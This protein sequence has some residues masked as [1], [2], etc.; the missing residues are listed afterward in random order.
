[1]LKLSKLADYAVVVLARLGDGEVVQ[2][3]PH[4]AGKTGLPRAYGCQGPQGISERWTRGQPA[5]RAGR[6][7]PGAS[8]RRCVTVA[9]VVSAIDGPVHLTA[10]VDGSPTSCKAEQCCCRGGWGWE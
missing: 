6:V 1:M 8:P 2:T 9:D 5:R 7:S 4:I 3:S 10:C